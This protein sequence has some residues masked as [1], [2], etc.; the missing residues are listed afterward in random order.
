MT[1]YLLFRLYA[2]LASHGDIAVGGYR[3]SYSHPGKSAILGLLAAALGIR[4]DEDEKQQRLTNSYGYAVRVDANGYLLTDFHTI[5][6]A[7]PEHKVNHYTRGDELKA[8]KVNTIL[9]TRDY[10]CDALYTICLW[11]H[12]EVLYSLQQLQDALLK[13]KF[14]LYLGRKSCPLALPVQAQICKADTIKTAFEQAEFSEL[15]NLKF[16]K[17]IAIYSDEHIAGM[18]PLKTTSRYDI[19]LNRRRWQFAA[20]DEHHFVVEK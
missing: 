3:P 11:Q 16:D 9:S 18:Q 2:P 5:Q 17:N 8:T 4:R 19:P 20:R 6:T 14:T 1:D 7:H 13:P 10:R 15:K 12:T